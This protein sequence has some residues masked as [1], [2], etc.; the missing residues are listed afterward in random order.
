M[1]YSSYLDLLNDEFK[2]RQQTNRSYSLRAFAR[3]LDMSAP[4]LSQIMNRKQGL[5]VESAEKVAQKLK[6]NSEKKKWF[7]HSV[8]ELHS[9]SE[10]ERKE[11]KDKILS[12]KKEAQI[13]EKVNLE[14]FKI[15][16]D[17]YHFAIIELTLLDG[18]QNDIQWISKILGISKIEA[19]EAI[20]RMKN[21]SLL[22]E[23]NGTLVSTAQFF[24]TPSDV[25]SDALKKFNSQLMQKAI[26][27][28]YKQDVQKREYS[29]NFFA[30]NKEDLPLIKQK[31]R[32]FRRELTFEA[33]KAEE[34]NSVYCLGIQ[35]YSLLE[36]ED[37]E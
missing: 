9:R 2:I 12:Y 37:L 3:D 35:L 31:I 17:W 20:E 36:D 19:T 21:L 14:Y 13:Y 6:L 32:N 7:C 8:G 10:K 4:R 25:P 15:I 27:A 1:Q 33:E 24:V 22:K 29:S 16:S 26:E 30:I 11:F 23:E 18:F 28:M 5:S 34:K